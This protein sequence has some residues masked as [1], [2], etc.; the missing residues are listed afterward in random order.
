MQQGLV[1]EADI[2]VSLR[3]LFLARMK[4][5]LFDPPSM[6]PYTSIPFSE[7]NSPAHQAFALNVADKSM[8][9]LKN[10]GILPLKVPKYKT[11]AV[12][13][14]NAASLAAIEGNYHGAPLDPQMPI[15][16]LKAAL[17]TASPQVHVLYEQGSPY[18][19]GTV[20]PVPRTLFHPEPGST[21][22][23]L[24]AEYF[25]GTSI[26]G[27]P[28]LS[29]IDPQLDFDWESVSPLPGSPAGGFAVRWTGVVVPPSPGKYDF[30]L[31]VSRCRSCQGNNHVLVVVDGKGV[32]YGERS[33]RCGDAARFR[34][35]AFLN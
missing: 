31:R 28:V 11:I 8:V 15:D 5:G 19:E 16:A 3:R 21:Q 22:E 26:K 17:Q 1:S 14:P 18:A 13:G 35:A 32:F 10:D 25:A 24:Q 9:L 4:L 12:I 29:R 6:V 30:T 34:P 27:K 2:D 33:L 7:V 23:G 20:L